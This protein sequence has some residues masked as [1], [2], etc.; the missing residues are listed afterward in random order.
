MPR[1]VLSDEDLLRAILKMWRC[2]GLPFQRFEISHIAKTLRAMSDAVLD[3]APS[4]L[5]ED[6]R[7][8]LTSRYRDRLR[9]ISELEKAI[10]PF[11]EREEHY[12]SALRK[13]YDERVMALMAQTE[14]ASD[15]APVMRNAIGALHGRA[16]SSSFDPTPDGE[17]AVQKFVDRQGRASVMRRPDVRLA[18]SALVSNA[19]GQTGRQSNSVREC[20]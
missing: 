2:R 3:A 15:K 14:I 19:Q 13:V 1:R 4:P 16:S 11:R 5:V 7:K 17:P 9:A 20:P 10:K 12:H 8:S 18:F 6:D